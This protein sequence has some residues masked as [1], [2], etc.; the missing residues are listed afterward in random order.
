MRPTRNVIVRVA[1]G[2]DVTSGL[3]TW[4]FHSLDPATGLPSE[5]PDQGFLPPNVIAPEG[6]GTLSFTIELQDGLPTGTE[7]KNRATIVFDSEAPIVTPEWLN[8][9]DV[10]APTSQVGAA[11]ADLLLGR[12]PSSWSGSRRALGIRSYDVYVFRRTEG[13]RSSGWRG[14]TATSRRL[15]GQIGPHLCLLL[16]RA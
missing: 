2:L 13:L 6:E 11:A 4:H 16:G 8:T 1:G 5:D 3:L 15:V 7:Y 10:T 9:I 12:S 14:V